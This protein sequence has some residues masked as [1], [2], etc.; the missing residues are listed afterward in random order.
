[1]KKL[2]ILAGLLLLCSSA[3]ADPRYP[4]TVKDAQTLGDLMGT[5]NIT[6]DY[7]MDGTAYEEVVPI[8]GDISIL[9]IDKAIEN[10]IITRR[11]GL[12]ATI[13]ANALKVQYSD[14]IGTTIDYSTDADMQAALAQHD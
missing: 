14:L 1:M 13:K 10:R 5:V 9:A 12:D 8:V 11:N 2:F 6:V 3:F 7:T 4:Y